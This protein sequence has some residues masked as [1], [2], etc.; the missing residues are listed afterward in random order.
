MTGGYRRGGKAAVQGTPAFS[1]S[2]DSEPLA[3]PPAT[4]GDH[5]R[6]DHSWSAL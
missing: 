6:R 1:V 5:R 2:H 3:A 4:C